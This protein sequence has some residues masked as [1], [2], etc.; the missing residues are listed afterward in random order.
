MEETETIVYWPDDWWCT[1]DELEDYPHRSD[2]YSTAHFPVD[3]DHEMIDIEIHR[4]NRCWNDSFEF[5]RSK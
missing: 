3:W 5:P 1:L 2:D 4:L